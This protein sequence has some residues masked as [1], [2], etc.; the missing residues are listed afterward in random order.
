MRNPVIVLELSD[1]I[2]VVRRGFNLLV[3]VGKMARDKREPA[4]VEK[5][6]LGFLTKQEPTPN[7]DVSVEKAKD[8]Y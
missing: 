2:A 6:V 3:F 1:T 8:D 5:E 7:E 4:T